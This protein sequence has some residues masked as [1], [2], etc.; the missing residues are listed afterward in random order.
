MKSIQV[1]SICICLALSLTN[2]QGQINESFD[3]EHICTC[4]HNDANSP[5]GVSWSHNHPKGGWMFSY[6]VMPMW[7]NGD[8]NGS[9]D[10]ENTDIYENFM[11][12]PQKMQMQ[13]H[14]LGL[15]YSPH[16]RVTLMA[17]L[18]FLHNSMDL[19]T[20]MGMLFTTESGGV[21][22]FSLGA[23]ISIV[24]S[25]KHSFHG[26]A[27][28]SFPTGSINQKD[29][30]PMM[31]DA[32]LAYPM[33]MGSGTWDPTIGFTYNGHS[34]I[35]GWGAQ[36]SYK[37]R[38]G[39]NHNDYRLGNVFNSTAWAAFKAFDLMQ[40][41]VR[42]N[43][44][45][46]QEINGADP[47][48]NPMMMPLFNPANS[49]GSQIDIL[50]GVSIHIDKG[51]LNGLRL[52]AEAGYPMYQHVSGIQM[53]RSVIATFGIQYSLGKHCTGCE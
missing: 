8:I 43:F 32:Q 33:Q 42:M 13:M 30:T 50:G 19:S 36:A 18:N 41:S 34:H 11:V 24:E 15:M 52:A 26:Q 53:K 10:I 37:P 4:S 40:F 12:A 48:L 39:N 3:S 9:T 38:F 22:D 25:R 2:L 17:M 27:A 23:L 45:N 31:D 5:I 49:G 51:A 7:M 1:L 46:T 47:M 6:R 44:S 28:L 14:M 35:Y 29:D 21:G 20:K 16:D